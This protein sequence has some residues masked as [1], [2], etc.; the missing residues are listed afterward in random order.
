MKSAMEGI[1]AK[2]KTEFCRYYVNV[3]ILQD[4]I[5]CRCRIGCFPGSFKD[6]RH[7]SW[8]A[9]G[10]TGNKRNPFFILVKSCVALCVSGSICICILRT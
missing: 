3:C 8:G 6:R 9:D 7:S 1:L 5:R 2:N 10:S 4:N